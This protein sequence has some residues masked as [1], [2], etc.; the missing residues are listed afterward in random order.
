MLILA[1]EGWKGPYWHLI[2]Q[3]KGM[4]N[5]IRSEGIKW[6]FDQIKGPIV[7]FILGGILEKKRGVILVSI[8]QLYNVTKYFLKKFIKYDILREKK[9]KEWGYEWS[10]PFVIIF[11]FWALGI[12]VIW[13]LLCSNKIPFQ[14][15]PWS[16]LIVGTKCGGTCK[17][18]GLIDFNKKNYIISLQKK[19]HYHSN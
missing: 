15:H 3:Y 5:I 13:K 9:G 2:K 8:I 18:V 17:D 16:L 19:L 1:A 11:A 7:K 6:N 12:L 14:S 4:T 10:P